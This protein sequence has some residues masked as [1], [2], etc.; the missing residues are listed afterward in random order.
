MKDLLTDHL[1]LYTHYQ[2]TAHTTFYSTVYLLLFP[3][4][5]SSWLI[6]I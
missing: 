2:S 4:S 3:L 1:R 6:L 5:F